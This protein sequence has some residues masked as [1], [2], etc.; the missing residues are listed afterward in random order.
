M[1]NVL[2]CTVEEANRRLRNC[3]PDL[4][5]PKKAA[6]LTDMNLAMRQAGH[7]EKFRAMV[8]TRAVARYSQAMKNHRNKTNRMYR[9][10][11][12]RERFREE[13]G[14]KTTSS[15]WMRKGGFTTVINISATK[16]N[17]LG[18][19]V[20]EALT[21]CPAPTGTRTKVQ[22]RP[23]RSVREALVK[24]NPFPRPS[25]ERKYCPW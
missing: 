11:E 17:K 10:K 25:C 20:E 3:H 4:P 18:L 5:W 7:T 8:T 1:D 19:A 13:K 14:G 2:Y 6:F 21:N 23:G 16:D 15:D 22:Q 24:G 9:N 12:E